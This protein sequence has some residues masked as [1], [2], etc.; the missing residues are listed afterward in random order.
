M[1][2]GEIYDRFIYLISVPKCVCCKS[3]LDFGSGPL[4]DGCLIKYHECTN[5][6]CSRCSKVLSQCS[7]SMDYLKKH[8]V[9]KMIKL[10][11]YLQRE[12]NLAANSLIYSLKRENRKD[13]IDFCSNRLSLS[14]LN[15]I[16]KPSDYIITNV[17]RRKRS[18]VEFGYDHAEAL[19][20]GIASKLGCKYECF[21]ISKNKTEQKALRG[22]ARKL[23]TSYQIK[24]Q[25][26]LHG[27]KVIIV[28]DV[29]TSGASMGAVA[30]L[31]KKLGA[32]EI[33]GASLGITYKDQLD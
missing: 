12:E 33:V 21:T 28:D 31:C 32:K 24:K 10:F 22:E 29:V 5:R 20:R 6:N 2:L 8:R 19:A 3:R 26:D 25:I 16:D 1:K 14:V 15:S 4:C 27:K 23:N 13:V 30:D 9:V 7:C 18:V 17:P 11:R